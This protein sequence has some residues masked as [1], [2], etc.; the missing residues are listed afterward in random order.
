[1]WVLGLHKVHGEES[2]SA[3]GTWGAHPLLPL[4]PLFHGHILIALMLTLLNL[5][6]DLFTLFFT[7]ESS[8][9]SLGCSLQFQTLL[10]ALTA[11]RI[12]PSLVLLFP[13]SPLRPPH[14]PWF[15]FEYPPCSSCYLLLCECCLLPS[16][17]NILTLLLEVGFLK[18]IK[19]SK[20]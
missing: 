5:L 9:S 20:N 19:N 14:P 13:Q 10:F 7:W 11:D 17:L 16:P 8:F 4:T 3:L 2:I 15:V 18:C 12:I 1:M 6:I